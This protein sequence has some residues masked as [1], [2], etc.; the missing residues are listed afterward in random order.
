M[1]YGVQVLLESRKA[2]ETDSPLESPINN[3]WMLAQWDPSL[4]SDFHNYKITNLHCFKALMLWE[5]ASTAIGGKHCCW[6]RNQWLSAKTQEVQIETDCMDTGVSM[7]ISPY[8]PPRLIISG[9]NSWK[10]LTEQVFPNFK[11][12]PLSFQWHD[13]C[14][15]VGAPG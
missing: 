6:E 15:G 8:L 5:F 13:G 3:T 9:R 12:D 1:T 10:I 11:N 14:G 2:K 4:T 7:R